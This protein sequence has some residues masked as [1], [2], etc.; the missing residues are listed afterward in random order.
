MRVEYF[1]ESDRAHRINE[2]AGRRQADW[3]ALF[4]LRL[5]ANGRIGGRLSCFCCGCS[6]AIVAHFEKGRRQDVLVT[7]LAHYSRCCKEP[8]LFRRMHDAYA[9]TRESLHSVP[10]LLRSCNPCSLTALCGMVSQRRQAVVEVGLPCC[11]VQKFSP[12]SPI[13]ATMGSC[14]LLF[15]MLCWDQ[16]GTSRTIQESNRVTID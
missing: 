10:K 12:V 7:M 3:N 16:F 14:H 8:G 1:G 11:G 6:S 9:K 4:R 15:C 5:N 13:W 2:R